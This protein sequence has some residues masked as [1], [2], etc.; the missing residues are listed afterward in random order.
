MTRNCRQQQHFDISFDIKATFSGV[1]VLVLV[2]AIG[3]WCVYKKVKTRGTVPTEDK[4]EKALLSQQEDKD[5]DN[6]KVV[7]EVALKANSEE[8]EE[9]PN[10]I[11]KQVQ[12][13][14]Q[15]QKQEQK[16]EEQEEEQNPEQRQVHEKSPC[17]RTTWGAAHMQ[18]T[19]LHQRAPGNG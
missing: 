6:G 5:N 12:K 17:Q 2:I 16:K 3:A 1:L 18:D 9:E 13:K 10:P 14:G 4:A 11:Q 15:E 19:L 8:Q 7:I